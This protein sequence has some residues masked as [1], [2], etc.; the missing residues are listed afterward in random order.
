MGQRV[1]L[2]KADKPKKKVSEKSSAKKAAKDAAL[3]DE[4]GG[5]TS[6]IQ[7]DP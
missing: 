2:H 4:V 7:F 1:P 6:Q 3:T 5:C